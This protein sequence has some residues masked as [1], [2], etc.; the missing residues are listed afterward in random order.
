MALTQLAHTL[1]SE[2]FQQPGTCKGL[3]IDGTCGNGFDTEFLCRLGFDKVVAFDIQARAIEITR[4]RLVERSLDN[5][6]LHCASHTEIGRLKATEIDCAMFNFG[7]L[8]HG[9]KHIT[10]LGESSVQAVQHCCARLSTAGLISLMCY[11][12]HSQG[13][14]ETIH[15]DGFLASLS[16][17]WQVVRHTSGS[18]NPAAPRLTMLTRESE[19][20]ATN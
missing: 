12:G 5:Y 2:H 3:A 4:H 8:P 6:E 15:I 19:S 16:G 13:E 7:W 20:S 10:T 14:E 18:E 17:Q 1:I 9:D 11:P